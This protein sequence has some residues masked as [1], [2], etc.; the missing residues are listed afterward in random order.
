MVLVNFS[1]FSSLMTDSY[2]L[3][4]WNVLGMH[5]QCTMYCAYSTLCVY[6]AFCDMLHVYTLYLVNK[7]V[8]TLAA[9]QIML[10][11]HVLIRGVL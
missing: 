11:R 5:R 7:H 2:R 9:G 8:S 6:I 4:V 1:C 3:Y 10:S